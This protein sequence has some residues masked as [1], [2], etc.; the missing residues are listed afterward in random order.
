MIA[1]N[2]FARRIGP[3]LLLTL[4]ALFYLTVVCVWQSKGFYPISGDEPH[5][6]LIADSLS[7]DRDL[8]VANNYRSETPV[9]QATKANLSDPVDISR[10]TRN[11]FSV[12][13]LGLPLILVIPYSLAG[14]IGAKVALALLAGLFPFV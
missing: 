5:Y 7:R 10:H 11:G 4:P 1:E 2:S 9:H 13:G 14:V 6:L 3:A 12:H 8:L